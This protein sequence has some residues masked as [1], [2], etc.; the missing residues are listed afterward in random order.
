MNEPGE[1]FWTA[2]TVACLAWY[3]TMTVFVAFRGVIDIR[4]M[5]ARLRKD[6]SLFE[7]VNQD[8]PDV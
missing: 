6:Q 8:S 7:E 3:T 4:N 5:L 2:I 1:W